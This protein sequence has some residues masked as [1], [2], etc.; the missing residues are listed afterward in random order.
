MGTREGNFD[1]SKGGVIDALVYIQC[2]TAS[3]QM[4]KNNHNC[5][6][7]CLESKSKTKESQKGWFG[8]I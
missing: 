8:V 1:K 3:C 2:E 4:V 6:K 7:G 5:K